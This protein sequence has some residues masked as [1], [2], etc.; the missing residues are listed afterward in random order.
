[1]K[2]RKIDATF[3]IYLRYL[4]Q[5]GNVSKV[6]LVRRYPDYAPRS[7]YRHASKAV[8]EE[9]IDD[10]RK[11]N[12]GR[13]RK[14]T[15]REERLII[16]T[17]KSL[18][19]SVASFTAKRIQE[20]SQLTHV[21]TK[22]IHRVLHKHGYNYLHARKKGLVTTKDKVLR[23]KFAKKAKNF[24]K[25]FW[26]KRISFYFDGVGF[27]HKT[28][29]YA[30]ATFNFNHGMEETERGIEYDWKGEERR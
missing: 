23:L 29:P 18:R 15:D 17:M 14:L 13:P 6:E 4:H 19:K 24:P 5:E 9:N 26:T 11:Q 30:E 25:D 28:N 20:E 1:M 7:I 22:T 16:N 3:S 2:K 27:A 21:S 8:V 10:Q 12:R